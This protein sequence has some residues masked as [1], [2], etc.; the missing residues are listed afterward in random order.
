MN[1]IIVK[2]SSSNIRAVARQALSG[3]WIK[4]TLAVIV[5]ML[6]LTIPMIIVDALLGN[7]SADP[8]MYAEEEFAADIA[9]GQMISL[10][11]AI[12]VGGAFT[13]GMTMF[14]LQMVRQKT[15]SIGHVFSGFGHF[16]KAFGL[17]FMMSLFISLW[18]LLLIVP[19]II[20]SLR[21]SQAFYILADD[22]TKGVMQCLRESKALMKGNKGKIF[23]LGLSFIPWILLAY[24]VCVI[25][26]AIGVLVA[27]A[28]VALGAVLMIAGFIVY[29]IALCV[30][31]AYIMS[32]ETIFFEMVTGKLRSA[33]SVP[34]VNNDDPVQQ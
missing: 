3:N 34:P 20:A 31:M 17:Y 19:G 32:A 30:I 13:L 12:L 1:N 11:Y 29:L 26:I 8:L 33:D 21:Y 10:L 16:F 22:P 2:E 27:A 15:A 9:A 5:F 6:C 28:A 14:F 4:S 18:S 25:I 23:C 24:L 7:W